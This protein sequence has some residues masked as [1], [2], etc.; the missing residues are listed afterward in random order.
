MKTETICICEYGKKPQEK[1]QGIDR[2]V[3]YTS[4]HRPTLENEIDFNVVLT[5]ILCDSISF[6]MTT[7]TMTSDHSLLLRVTKCGMK[8]KNCILERPGVFTRKLDFNGW[9]HDIGKQ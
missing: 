3:Q 7:N 1:S 9:F 2:K 4:L 6:S 5:V 8:T